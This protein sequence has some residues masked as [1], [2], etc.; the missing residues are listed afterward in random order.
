M[1]TKFATRNIEKRITSQQP[2]MVENTEVQ[3]EFKETEVG[4]IPSDWE[5]K[6][7]GSVAEVKRGKFTPRPRNDPR[8]YGGDIPFVQT[9]DVT[10]SGG[11]ISEYTQTL[12]QDGLGVSILFKKGTIL[13][14][15]AANIGYTGVLEIDMACPDSL[16]AINGF[17]NYSNE[18]LN[19]LFA[20][21]R[22]VKWSG[23]SAQ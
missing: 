13:M 6:Q 11:R 21:K 19:C 5:V 14:T 17:K 2:A 10:N 12:N 15:I 16:V 7:I 22:Q 9:G 23:L 18:Y 8:F 20:Y 3:A 1:G 4:R